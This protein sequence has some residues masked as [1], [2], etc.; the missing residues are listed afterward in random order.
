VFRLPAVLT[1]GPYRRSLPLVYRRLL[2]RV[3]RRLPPTFRL[4][5]DALAFVLFFGAFTLLFDFGALTEFV[6]GALTE[7]VFGTLTEFGF[8]TFIL[9]VRFCR[10]TPN[11]AGAFG[12][13]DVVAPIS[14]LYVDFLT[15]GFTFVS[16][17]ITFLL[18]PSS[19]SS[20]S[21]SASASI[22]P[23][24]DLQ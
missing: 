17:F 4:L 2:R 10:F 23:M 13:F 1:G 14:I 22:I 3:L 12:V 24:S 7:F 11:V 19:S 16:T 20:A 9:R 21:A 8:G 5:D 6:F 15:A 18:S